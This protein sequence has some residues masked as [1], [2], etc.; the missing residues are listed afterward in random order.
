MESKRQGKKE[1]TEKG[2][3]A[4]QFKKRNKRKKRK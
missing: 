3:K 1:R 2:R 4:I